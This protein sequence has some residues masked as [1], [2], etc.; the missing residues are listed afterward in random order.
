MSEIHILMIR[1]AK[2]EWVVVSLCNKKK[3]KALFGSDRLLGYKDVGHGW[4]IRSL[5][6]LRGLPLMEMFVKGKG[7]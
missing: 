2:V 4:L 5:G 3:V 7:S 6:A 1:I